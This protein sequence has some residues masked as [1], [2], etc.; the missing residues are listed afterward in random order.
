MC[1]TAVARRLQQ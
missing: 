1:A